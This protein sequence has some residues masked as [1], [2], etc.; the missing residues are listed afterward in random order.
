[1][2]C[3]RPAILRRLERLTAREREVFV[4]VAAGLKS[5]EIAEMLLITPTTVKAHRLQVME[6]LEIPNLV[7]LG[8]L[9]ERVGIV[10]PSA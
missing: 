4:L 5:R 10:W 1:M 2:R 8:R 9:A 7:L 3:P 6:K